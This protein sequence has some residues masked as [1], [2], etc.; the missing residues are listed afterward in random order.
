MKPEK[1][2]TVTMQASPS[3][4]SNYAFERH[5]MPALSRYRSKTEKT[6]FFLS[7]IE[8]AI[9][10]RFCGSITLFFG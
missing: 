6:T 1:R 8:K 10:G 9:T 3:V 2:P 4:F 7:H 5:Y